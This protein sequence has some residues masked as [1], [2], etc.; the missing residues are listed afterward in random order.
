MPESSWTPGDAV[1]NTPSKEDLGNF[2]QI[3]SGAIEIVPGETGIFT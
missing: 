2:Y 1:I 3:V